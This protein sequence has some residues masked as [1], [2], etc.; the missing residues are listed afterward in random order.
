MSISPEMMNRITLI[1]SQIAKNTGSRINPAVL[2]HKA[3]SSGLSQRLN[4]LRTLSLVLLFLVIIM[5]FVVL[6]AYRSLPEDPPRISAKDL[7]RLIQARVQEEVVKNAHLLERNDLAVSW[8]V[9]NLDMVEDI[10]ASDI[11][12]TRVFQSRKGS[13]GSSYTEFNDKGCSKADLS[14]TIDYDASKTTPRLGFRMPNEENLINMGKRGL[15]SKL[16][17]SK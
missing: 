6:F 12:G 7:R 16:R 17:M 2:I 15:I 5:A 11:Q 8:T 3:R 4:I 10:P 9:E 13:I 14:T 1:T